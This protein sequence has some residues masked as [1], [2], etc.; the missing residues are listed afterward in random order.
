MG[1]QRD[2]YGRPRQYYHIFKRCAPLC[3][4]LIRQ[5]GMAAGDV[6]TALL[7]LELAG[8]WSV[9]QEAV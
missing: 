9:M 7:D 1:A 5:S 4:E 2:N 3:D 8:S 6:Q